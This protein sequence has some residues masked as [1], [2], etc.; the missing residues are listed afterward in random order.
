MLRPLL[1]LT[2]VLV[3]AFAGFA[4][5]FIVWNW[6]PDRPVSELA[7]K[8]AQPP[9]E[10]RDIA[11]MKVHVRD[12]GPRADPVPVILIHGTSSSLHTWSGWADEL[13]K[14]RR[15]IRFDLPGFGLTGPS[16]EADYTVNAYVRFMGA[17]LDHY[18]L[19]RVVLAGNSLGGDIAWQTAHAIPE[20]VEK[21]VLV[22]SAGYKLD[23]QSIPIGFRIASIPVLNKLGTVVLPRRLIVQSLQNVY[24]DPS[25]VTDELVDLY[26]DMAVR[27]GNRTA[28]AQRFAQADFGKNA[29]NITQ[30]K[31][32]VLILWGGRD[33][34]IPPTN[35]ERFKQDIA[36]SKLMIL[37]ELGHVPHEEGPSQTLMPVIEFL[38]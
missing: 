15:V 11:G 24:G 23:A 19:R 13:K 32:P 17:F 6:Q 31:L 1:R 28:L 21:L 29:E 22:N 16:P 12:E 36:A 10:F 7:Q 9:S 27:A 26:F 25:K 30:L 38:R 18:G 2:K 5:A 33:K 14:T 4:T 34:L 37:P 35:G 3:L 8:W 20:R